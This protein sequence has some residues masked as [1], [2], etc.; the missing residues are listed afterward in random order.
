MEDKNIDMES[1]D[2]YI[3]NQ[4][5]KAQKSVTSFISFMNEILPGKRAEI[6]F[7]MPMW[8]RVKKMSD[9]YVAISVAKQ[10]YTI[11][12][13]DE[14]FVEELSS[15]FKCGKRCA[16]IPYDNKDKEKL[17]REYVKEFVKDWE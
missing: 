9:G 11:H 17:I 1:V 7:S 6:V 12:F 16:S 4:G 5:E 13:S 3:R 2:N 8:K 14:E 15:M 10:H